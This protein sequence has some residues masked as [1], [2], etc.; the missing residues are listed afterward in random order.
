MTMRCEPKAMT[1]S[2][3]MDA[4]DQCSSCR[5]VLYCVGL[6]TCQ[7]S[8]NSKLC[9]SSYITVSCL[10]FVTCC[11]HSSG[12]CKTFRSASSQ[13]PLLHSSM[14]RSSGSQQQIFSILVFIMSPR[15]HV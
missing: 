11:Y 1:R 12:Q 4:L 9:I 2:E 8:A 10:S 7:N 15:T 5:R 14:S 3:C 6:K 13:P